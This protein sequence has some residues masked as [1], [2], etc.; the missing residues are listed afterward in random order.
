MKRHITLIGPDQYSEVTKALMDLQSQEEVHE[1][2]IQPAQSSLSGRQRRLYWVWM[3]DYSKATGYSKEEAHLDF[4]KRFLVKI[5][6]RDSKDYA[7]M[8]ESVRQVHRKGMP[9][10]A[11]H[12]QKMI[13]ELTSIMDADTHQMA[14]YMDDIHQDCNNRGIQLSMPE[15]LGRYHPTK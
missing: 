10:H 14:E 1:V 8:I 7:E 9:G 13:I 6:E 11:K 2:I 4:K 15:D 12:L 3:T 5:Y